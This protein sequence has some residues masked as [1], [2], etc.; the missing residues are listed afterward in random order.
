MGVPFIH[1]Y[2]E[3]AF[4]QMDNSYAGKD[5][6]HTAGMNFVLSDVELRGNFTRSVRAPAL[7]ELFLPIVETGSFAADPCDSGV[8]SS[9]SAI[10]ANRAAT[11]LQ[12]ALTRALSN[13]MCGMLRFGSRR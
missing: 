3:G 6:A 5:N 13:L 11:V 1:K 10:Q 7:T 8:N 2:M 4:R 9:D 12:T